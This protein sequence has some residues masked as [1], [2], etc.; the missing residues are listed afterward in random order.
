MSLFFLILVVG[1]VWATIFFQQKKRTEQTWLSMARD[2]GMTYL[3]SGQPSLRGQ[4]DGRVVRV[5]VY[6]EPQGNTSRTFT[7]FEIQYKHSLKPSFLLIRQGLVRTAIGLMGGQDILTGDRSF[8]AKVVLQ[9]SDEDAVRELFDSSLTRA[10]C[11]KLIGKSRYK[12]VR[13]THQKISVSVEG[14]LM[15]TYLIKEVLNHLTVFARTL[16]KGGNAGGSKE[17]ASPPPL[18]RKKKKKLPV[19]MP[20]IEEATIAEAKIEVEVETE[21]IVEVEPPESSPEPAPQPEPM[22]EPEPVP[23]PEP[24]ILLPTEAPRKTGP[25]ITK[26]ADQLFEEKLG[27]YQAGKRFERQFQGK[28]ISWSGTLTG[29]EPGNRERA[30]GS[31]TAWVAI[32]DLGSFPNMASGSGPLKVKY[33]IGQKRKNTLQSSMGEKI[34]IEG[35]LVKF[36]SFSNTLFVNSGDPIEKE[37]ATTTQRPRFPSYADRMTNHRKRW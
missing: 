32:L 35:E 36:D 7:S 28:D 8:D 2:L 1:I 6:K 18:P 12:N 27:R 20:V 29:I 15:S 16:E 37:K 23:E 34:V 17:P 13:V 4:F 24:E 31:E 14:K 33:G 10:A 3:N 22:L 30:F 11:E 26:I 9:G 5:K 19:Q 25:S 21:Q